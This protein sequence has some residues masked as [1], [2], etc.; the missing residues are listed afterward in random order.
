MAIICEGRGAGERVWI[1]GYC[2]FQNGEQISLFLF[3][4]NK[5]IEYFLVKNAM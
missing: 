4:F 3:G 1:M 2:T 5:S